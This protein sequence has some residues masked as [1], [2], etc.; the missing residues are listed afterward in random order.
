MP[1][2]S[3]KLA[4]SGIAACLILTLFVGFRYGWPEHHVVALIVIVI[5]GAVTVVFIRADVR[6][7]SRLAAMTPEQRDVYLSAFQTEQRERFLRR[8]RYYVV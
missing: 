7:F 4:M 8:L 5:S 2:P 6:F 1:E 3:H